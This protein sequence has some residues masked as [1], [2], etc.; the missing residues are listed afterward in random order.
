[1]KMSLFEIV[2]VTSTGRTIH[3]IAH[4]LKRQLKRWQDHYFGY[5]WNCNFVDKKYDFKSNCKK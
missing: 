1:M 4:I 3:Q 2:V 5:V